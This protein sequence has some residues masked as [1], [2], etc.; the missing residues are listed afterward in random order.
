MNLVDLYYILKSEASRKEFAARCKEAGLKFV[1]DYTQE[2][3]E[4][5]DDDLEPLL[6]RFLPWIQNPVARRMIG[7]REGGINIPQAID[8]NKLTS[9]SA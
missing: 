9:S 1:D 8:D 3:A 2:V 5:S 6:G 7:F 4:M